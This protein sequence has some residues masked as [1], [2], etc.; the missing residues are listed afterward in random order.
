M[1]LLEWKSNYSVKVPSIDR[2]HQTLLDMV[3]GLHDAMKSGQGSKVAPD[4][5]ARLVDYTREHFAYEESLMLRARYPDYAAH[6]AEHTK[7]TQQVLKI[8]QDLDKG[9]STITLS[10]AEF[11]SQWL[12]T[13]I[14]DRDQKYSECLLAA[15]IR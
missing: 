7:L 11:L 8:K 13:H 3:N 10:L 5:L 4:I 1:A 15:E 14:L 6:K 9:D 12:R 2:E